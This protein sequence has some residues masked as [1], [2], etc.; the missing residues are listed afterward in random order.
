MGPMGQTGTIGLH[1]ARMAR[2]MARASRLQP[3]KVLR[4]TAQG[5]SWFFAANYRVF[6]NTEDCLWSVWSELTG[7]GWFL[8][9][10]RNNGTSGRTAG[11]GMSLFLQRVTTQT[12][13]TKFKNEECGRNVG[14]RC[15]AI[16]KWAWSFGGGVKGS[17]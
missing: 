3:G 15:G 4:Q 7:S 1:R 17:R 16:R 9:R 14:T 10:R 11:G 13:L 2:H 5:F 6:R 12:K 8:L